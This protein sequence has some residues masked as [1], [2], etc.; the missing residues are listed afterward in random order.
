MSWF[1]QIKL[2]TTLLL[3]DGYTTL[4]LKKQELSGTK[5]Y[6]QTSAEEKSVINH[7]IFTKC[8]KVW[9]KC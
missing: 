9:R 7:D 3:I 8:H 5:A 1:Q 2:R 4:A 6:E